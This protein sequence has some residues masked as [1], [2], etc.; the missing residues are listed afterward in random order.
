MKNKLFIFYFKIYLA[1]LFLFATY[2]LIQRYDD[3]GYTISEWLINYQGGFTRRGLIGE[4]I[5][6]FSILTNLN[7]IKSVVIFQ[8]FFYLLYLLLIFKFFKKSQINYLLL[9]AIFSPLFLI[10]PI[11]ELEVLARKEIFIFIAF[12]LFTNN[13]FNFQKNESLSLI[14]FSLLLSLCILIWEGVLFYTSFFILILF[15]KH[16]NL[17][18]KNF[19]YKFILGMLPIIFST[20]FVIFNKLTTD[21]INLMCES[22]NQCYGAMTYL[23]NDLKS[24]I[25]EVKSKIHIS[26]LIR[27]I[28]IFLLGFLPL[29]I[30]L[31]NSKLNIN[32]SFL[33]IFNKN[34]LFIF[35]LVFSPS[36]IFFYIAQDWGRWINISYTLSIL[37]YFYCLNNNLIVLKKNYFFKIKNSIITF[38]FIIF[39]FGWSPKVLMSDDISSIPIYRK[40]LSIIKKLTNNS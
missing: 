22:V 9:F 14:Y 11:S 39:S 4:A 5:Y 26:F 33:K 17:F 6:Y 23:G 18:S 27:Y 31:K 40:S 21:Q 15:L 20:Y 2:F 3:G 35:F 13:I 24:N 36:L 19:F 7:F 25:N 29:I 16:K 12:L 32:V 30:L 28:F 10:Y 37:T 8:I 1:V 34:I 38:L